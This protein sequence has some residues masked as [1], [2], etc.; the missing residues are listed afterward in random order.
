MKRTA[1][2]TSR[3]WASP[4]RRFP[5]SHVFLW[6]NVNSMT[7]SRR[8]SINSSGA[9]SNNNN[10][11]N[12]NNNLTK[13][14][15]YLRDNE[16]IGIRFGNLPITEMENVPRIDT[17]RVILTIMGIIIIGN[18]FQINRIGEMNRENIYKK[19]RQLMFEHLRRT[20]KRIYYGS[21]NLI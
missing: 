13:F 3:R 6:I 5:P 20:G 19:I 1:G 4:R 14:R 12:Y 7:S 11:N 18:R 10:N 8:V 9:K 17:L 15:I 2:A 16:T 21:L